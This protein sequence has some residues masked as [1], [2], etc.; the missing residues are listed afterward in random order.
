MSTPKLQAFYK[1]DNWR[2]LCKL[3]K[4]ERVNEAG[5]LICEHC[6]KPIVRKYDCIAH[7]VIELTDDNV[8]DAEIS[9]NPANIQLVHFRCHNEIHRRFGASGYKRSVYIVWGSPCAGKTTWVGDVA[10]K[11]DIILDIDKLWAAIKS[12][13]CG[14]YEKPTALK[15]N[16]FA[17][18]D[19]MLDMIRV[20]QGKWHD[21]YIIGGYPLS[22]ER[23]R[24]QTAVGADKLIHIDTPKELCLARADS[25]ASEWHGYVEEW[26]SRYTPPISP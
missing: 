15:Q 23:E 1:G 25:K 11:D 9:L 21:A 4:V 26:W 2:R 10:S 5:D 22:A 12:D 13:A 17:L 14:K 19:A 6:G 24:L 3:I 18:R 16:V 20:R 8:D 7:H